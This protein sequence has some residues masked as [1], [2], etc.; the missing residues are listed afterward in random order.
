MT[1][2]PFYLAYFKKL[3]KKKPGSFLAPGLGVFSL[4]TKGQI[5]GTSEMQT[6]Q[7]RRAAAAT[8]T[9]TAM[10]VFCRMMLLFIFVT[11]MALNLILLK[12]K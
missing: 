5:Q 9:I 6:R 3:K 8:A 10:P 2:P 7:A 11:D 4:L 1:I 12:S